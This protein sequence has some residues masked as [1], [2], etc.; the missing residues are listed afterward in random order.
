MLA[1]GPC[2]VLCYSSK[3]TACCWPRNS[4]AHCSVRGLL[5]HPAGCHGSTA[6]GAQV[7][8]VASEP[9]VKSNIVPSTAHKPH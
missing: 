4:R 7:G 2:P 1:C 6:A 8:Q 3:L 9:A 5:E